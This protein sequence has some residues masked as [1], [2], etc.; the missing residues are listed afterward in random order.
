MFSLEVSIPKSELD[1]AHPLPGPW[2]DRPALAGS[3][4]LH[5]VC[6]QNPGSSGQTMKLPGDGP[7]DPSETVLTASLFLVPVTLEA[8]WFPEIS[9]YLSVTECSIGAY[10]YVTR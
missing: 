8:L 2:V 5:A 1:A 4:Q 6:T 10:I 9:L 7:Q 3:G